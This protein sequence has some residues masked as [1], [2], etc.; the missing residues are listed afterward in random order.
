MQLTLP[1]VTIAA[2]LD[3]INPCAISVLLLTLGFL[4]SLNSDRKKILSV[5]GLYIFGIFITYI[6]IGLG[7]LSTLTLFGVPRIIS[8]IGASVLIITSLINL[9]EVYVPNFPIKLAIPAFIK[10]QIA[11]QMYKASFISA[12]FMGVIVGLFE[13]PCTGGP[14]LMILGLLHDKSTLINGAAYLLYYNLIFISPLVI[15]LLLGSSR[16]LTEKIQSFR[17]RN[18]KTTA[19]ISALATLAL[20]IIIFVI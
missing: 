18:S 2:L 11:A 8:K 1:V 16:V 5:A 6:L 14:Y 3:S 10:P 15:I 12:F 17:K 4:V 7:V 13:F 9:A 19:V 20:G